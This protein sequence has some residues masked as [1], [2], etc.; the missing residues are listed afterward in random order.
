MRS[1]IRFALRRALLEGG[2][3]CAISVNGINN[4]SVYGMDDLL[5]GRFACSAD[6]YAAATAWWARYAGLSKLPESAD[7]ERNGSATASI[8]NR[9]MLPTRSEGNSAPIDTI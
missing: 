2:K 8:A 9:R 5:I 3:I 7:L 6:E 4:I 1:H